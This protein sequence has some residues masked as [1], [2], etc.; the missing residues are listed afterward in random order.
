MP[1][2]LVKSRQSYN[3]H[4]SSSV[5]CAAPPGDPNFDVSLFPYVAVNGSAGADEPPHHPSIYQATQMTTMSSSNFYRHQFHRQQRDHRYCR[6][7]DDDMWMA[8]SLLQSSATSQSGADDVDDDDGGGPDM[9]M[10]SGA[11]SGYDDEE[12][13]DNVDGDFPMMKGRNVADDERTMSTTGMTI[14]R[15]GRMTTGFHDGVVERRS[16]A[17][18]RRS[19]DKCPQCRYRSSTAVNDANNC[20]SE[21]IRDAAL[22]TINVDS[23]WCRTRM[24]EAAHVDTRDSL[25]RSWSMGRRRP[26][27][28]SGGAK[29]TAAAHHRSR[30]STIGN[31]SI[32]GCRSSRGDL[33]SGQAQ[34]TPPLTGRGSSDC[35]QVASKVDTS[36]CVDDFT[37]SSGVVDD[38]KA[39]LTN[40]TATVK[41]VPSL[42]VPDLV[43]CRCHDESATSPSGEQ[44]WL[45][46]LDSCGDN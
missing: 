37:P 7:D 13:A 25:T 16:S 29:R 38:L 27:P 1:V 3:K 5:N 34:H 17:I 19:I 20:A 28:I 10:T 8:K 39:A 9:T 11:S 30:Y 31:R 43:T 12:T 42:S 24:T 15:I 6:N 40:S 23:D 22:D 45:M 4:L 2:W 35:H 44:Q 32:A 33:G 36:M 26:L 41:R 21:P 14:D 46:T 18:N